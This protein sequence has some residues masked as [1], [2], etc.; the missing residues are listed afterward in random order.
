MMNSVRGKHSSPGIYFKETELTY[1][2]K[3]LGITTLGLAGETLKGPAFEPI[4]IS[5]WGE[6]QYYFGG[7]S[8]KK[9]KDSQYP[10]YEL[11]FIAKS[12]LTESKQLEVVR[13]L[14][15]SGYNAGPAWIV[16]GTDDEEEKKYVIAVIRS[17]G[18]YEKYFNGYMFDQCTGSPQYDF[19]LYDAKCVEIEC[20]KDLT[21]ELNCNIG[22]AITEDEECTQDNPLWNVSSNNLGRFVLKVTKNDDSVVR[23]AVSLNSGAKDYIYD[24]LGK[25]NESGS[26]PLFVEELYDVALSQYIAAGKI[27]KITSELTILDEVI[28]QPVCDPVL[29]FLTIPNE[30]LRRSNLEQTFVFDERFLDPTGATVY[31]ITGTSIEQLDIVQGGVYQVRYTRAQ[32]ADGVTIG[33]YYAPYK[34]KSG[35]TEVHVVLEPNTEDLTNDSGCTL[36][37]N[38]DECLTRKAIYINAYGRYFEMIEATGE[39]VQNPIVPVQIDMN[40]YKERFRPAETPWFVSQVLGNGDTFDVKRLFKFIT[41]SDG[42]TANKQVK[43]SIEKIR[44]DDGT[45]S[46]VIR[47]Y[48]DSDLQQNV[49]ERFNN[50]TMDPASSTYIGKKIGTANGEYIIKSKYVSLVINDDDTIKNLVPCG[51]LGYPIRNWGEGLEMMPYMYNTQYYDDIRVRKQYFGMSD[52]LGVDIDML[53]YKGVAAYKDREYSVNGYT[54]GFHLDTRANLDESGLS[55]VTVT[56]DQEDGYIFDTVTPNASVG[57]P[58]ID[59][60]ELMYGT[61]FEDV[62]ARKFTVYPYGGYDGW[63]IYRGAR[64]TGDEF[65]SNKYKGVWEYG[66]GKNFTKVFDTTGLNLEG[67][68]AISSDYYAF[69]AGYRQFANPE[70]VDINLF[71]TPGIDLFNNILLTEEAMN[72]IEDD[73]DGRKGDALYIVTTPDKPFGAS[74]AE[75]DMY[76]ADDIVDLLEDTNVDTSY[77]ATYFPW[78]KY[79]DSDSG[80]YINLPPTKDVMRNFAFTDNTAAPWFASAGINRGPVNCVKAHKFTK[81]TEEDTLYD[82][83]VNVIK[84]F[85][86]DGVKVWGNKTLSTTEGPLNRIN[87]RRLMIRVKKLITQAARQLIFEQNDATL[88]K[89][90]QSLVEPI[91]ANVRANR[92]ITDYRLDIQQSIECEDEHELSATIWIKPTPTLEYI[93]IN[94][95]ITAQC[96]TFDE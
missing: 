92:G 85:A 21:W 5:D 89:Q 27:T 91:L 79:F 52:I 11:P 51:N 7:T 47:D 23:Y 59:T 6:F 56:V 86:S 55:G 60:E 12:Y 88:R 2:A 44:P 9:F 53:N 30:D 49:L 19:L 43:I 4:T 16:T 71:A 94:F 96:V 3:S 35:S 66:E 57:V 32:N 64:T 83:R 68:N 46:V 87:V 14:G 48:N 41:I 38:P 93:S 29:D 26:S 17:K 20:Y 37:N 90:F 34:V 82:G 75:D 50:C 28:N 33:Y 84:T 62:N 31:D 78:I 63:D 77:A 65:K 40:N 58:V 15:L 81:Q 42:N 24:V 76:T 72:V 73:E 67:I 36:A 54:N 1:S 18:H 80:T 10:K 74:D 13:V 70:A 8:T 25:D 39:T 69:L 22:S 61:V 95:N 45:F